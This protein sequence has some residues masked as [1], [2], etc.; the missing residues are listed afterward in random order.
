MVVTIYA[1]SSPDEARFVQVDTQPS[2]GTPLF[3]LAQQML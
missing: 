2:N 1:G 3:L